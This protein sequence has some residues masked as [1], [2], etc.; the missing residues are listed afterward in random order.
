MCVIYSCANLEKGLSKNLASADKWFEDDVKKT[1]MLISSRRRRAVKLEGVQVK[2]RG[3]AI[4][5]S[6][7]VKYLGVWVDDELKWSEHIMAVRCLM[8]LDS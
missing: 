1:R 6:K 3:E 8:G 4:V 2:L 7:P 5:R